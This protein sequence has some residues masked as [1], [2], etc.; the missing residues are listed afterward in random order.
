MFFIL[1]IGSDQAVYSRPYITYAIAALCLILHIWGVVSADR[2]AAAANAA[3]RAFA[4]ELQLDEDARV[5]PAAELPAVVRGELAQ[6]IA[7]AD[8]DPAVDPALTA[9]ALDFG[10]ALRAIPLFGLGYIPAE[11]RPATL[12]TYQAVHGGCSFYGAS[13]HPC[14][15]PRQRK[16]APHPSPR[17]T[18]PA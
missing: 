2:H 1:P 7:E 12:I 11:G 14:L 5:D 17:S 13:T 3:Y 10:D 6:W 15:A 4:S 16:P 18:H 9:A 8:D